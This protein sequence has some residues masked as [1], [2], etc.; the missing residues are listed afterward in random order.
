[1]SMLYMLYKKQLPA[2]RKSKILSEL[3]SQKE[4]LTDEDEMALKE[5][6]RAEFKQNPVRF[7]DSMF[8]TTV[9]SLKMAV[10]KI[11]HEDF[12]ED[13]KSLVLGGEYGGLGLSSCILI[14]LD[15]IAGHVM[16]Q[17]DRQG[18]GKPKKGGGR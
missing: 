9:E 1:M 10:Y 12:E 7:L 15:W 16:E 6:F 4:D 17:I 3:L 13:M 8:R 18:L 14:N 5:A 11:P 2:I